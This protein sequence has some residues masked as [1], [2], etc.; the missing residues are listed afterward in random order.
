MPDGFV[1]GDLPD[2]W[3]STMGRELE[4]VVKLEAVILG[5]RRESC[6]GTKLRSRGPGSCSVE[7]KMGS[8][9]DNGYELF[10]DGGKT[11]RQLADWEK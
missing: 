11:R 3:A 1:S 10:R 9:M 4:E 8:L 2:C 6:L 7:K 5:D